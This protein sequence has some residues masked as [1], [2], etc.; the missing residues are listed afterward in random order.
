MPVTWEL[1]LRG[2]VSRSQAEEAGPRSVRAEGRPEERT[3]GFSAGV[4]VPISAA[5][6]PV[7]GALGSPA[8]AFLRP[9]ASA[10]ANSPDLM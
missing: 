9:C 4:H 5:G 8:T 10:V 1:K 6:F 3:G 7:L 2:S